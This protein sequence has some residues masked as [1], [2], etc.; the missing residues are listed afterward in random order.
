M[1][2]KFKKL[3]AEQVGT[4]N[5]SSERMTA[6]SCV[7]RLRIEVNWRPLSIIRQSA[8]IR[9]STLTVVFCLSKFRVNKQR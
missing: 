6:T 7:H 5:G 2:M 8:V 3:A 1:S 9:Q 4:L